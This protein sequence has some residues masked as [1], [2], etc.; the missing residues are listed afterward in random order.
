MTSEKFPKLINRFLNYVAVDTQS[1]E[2]AKTIPSSP[3]EVAFLADL[4][5]M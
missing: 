4:L 3:K 2:Q 5:R 1:D